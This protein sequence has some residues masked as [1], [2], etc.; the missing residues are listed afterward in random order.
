LSKG[1]ERISKILTDAG[2]LFEREKS[3]TDEKRT[4]KYRFDFFL[5]VYNICIEFQGRQHMV[6]T[7]VFHKTR[8]DFLKS[9]ERDRTK[10]SYCL[11]HNIKLYCIPYWELDNLKTVE[12]I[13]NDKFLARTKFHN[14]IV[15]RQQNFKT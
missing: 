14:D 8:S 9:Q 6:F 3:F 7:P 11:A 5:P 4:K 12:D 13:L 2:I 10:I 15:F 1:E